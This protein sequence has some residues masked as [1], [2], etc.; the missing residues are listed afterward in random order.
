MIL[1]SAAPIIKLPTQ[2]STLFKTILATGVHA[3]IK[4]VGSQK[5]SPK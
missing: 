4:I 5:K 2:E 1:S 3:S